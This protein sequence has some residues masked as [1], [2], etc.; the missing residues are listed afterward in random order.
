MNKEEIKILVCTV[1]VV[2][3]AKVTGMDIFRLPSNADPVGLMMVLSLP[4][5]LILGL[6]YVT[7][8]EK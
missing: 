7:A 1:F 3:F 8:G 6:A 2:W 5:S 4:V